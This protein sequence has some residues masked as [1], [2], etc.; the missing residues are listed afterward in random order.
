MALAEFEQRKYEELLKQ[1]VRAL[2]IFEMVERNYMSVENGAAA[3]KMSVS[4]FRKAM[5]DSGLVSNAS[6]GQAL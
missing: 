1:E 3:L 4:E 6:S 5:V 2:T